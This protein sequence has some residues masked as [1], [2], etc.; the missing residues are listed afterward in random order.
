MSIGDHFRGLTKM[1][2]HTKLT[3]VFSPSLMLSGNYDDVFGDFRETDSRSCIRKLACNSQTHHRIMNKDLTLGTTSV[4]AHLMNKASKT[5]FR[6]RLNRVLPADCQIKTAQDAW[7]AGAI[8]ATVATFVFP[9]ALL[10]LAYCV[11]QAKKKG[12]E[13]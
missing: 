6:E 11:V 3:A 5:T 8:F 1:I 10:A 2:P 7:Y 13:R 4:P 9:P 12:G